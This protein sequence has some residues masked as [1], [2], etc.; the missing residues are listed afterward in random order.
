MH[1]IDVCFLLLKPR[2][3]RFGEV[4][5]ILAKKQ[6]EQQ[7]LVGDKSPKVEG[8]GCSH[9]MEYVPLYAQTHTHTYIYVYVY[10]NI[11]II[12]MNMNIYIFF[13]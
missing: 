12:H 8:V 5:A 4:E 13:L 11:Y 6:K 3:P 7:D 9:V 10:V 2:H 1:D